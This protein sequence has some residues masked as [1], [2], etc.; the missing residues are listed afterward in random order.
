MRRGRRGNAPRKSAA[1]ARARG[2]SS[3]AGRSARIPTSART[4]AVSG[5][6]SR[7]SGTSRAC[8]TT[9]LRR[10]SVEKRSG[11]HATQAELERARD[12]VELVAAGMVRAATT[13]EIDGYPAVLQCHLRAVRAARVRAAWLR[14]RLTGFGECRSNHGQHRRI[15]A[16][17]VRLGVCAAA[18]DREPGWDWEWDHDRAA[19]RSAA[20]DWCRLRAPGSPRRARPSDGPVAAGAQAAAAATS[21]PPEVRI[22]GTTATGG[23]RAGCKGCAD[24]QETEGSPRHRT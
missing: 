2:L 20:A 15:E 7:A 10:A 13:W 5:G 17:V 18:G 9:W 3:R 21:G 6:A 24:T 19:H 14:E 12:R 23:H 11:I 8:L 1:C 22:G 4:A 16:A